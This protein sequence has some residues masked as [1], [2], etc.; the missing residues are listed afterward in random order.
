MSAGAGGR[1]KGRVMPPDGPTEQLRVAF[2]GMTGIFTRLVLQALLDAGTVVSGVFLA[3]PA[4][5]VLSPTVPAA[6]SERVPSTQHRANLATAPASRARRSLLPVADASPISL[7][8]DAGIPV[9]SVPRWD[10]LTLARLQSLV[11]DVIC[12]ACFPFR[13][14]PSVLT[15]PRHGCLNVHPSLLP[16]NRG[17]DPLFWTF[18]RGD[19]VTGVTIHQMD[20]GLDSGP[21]LL[22]ARITLADGSTEAALERQCAAVG[23]RLL[24]DALEALRTGK[25]APQR[26]D[27]ARA[28]RYGFPTEDDYWLA[29]D[30]DARTLFTFARGI[31]QRET[32]LRVQVD[33]HTYRVRA[34]LGYEQHSS[35]SEAAVLAGDELWLQCVNGGRLH[36]RVV[37]ER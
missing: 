5:L 21:I 27:Q 37:P 30:R 18:Q 24:V 29:P 23:G 34:A 33:G 2:L 19:T 13:L 8:R 9:Y 14:P 28:T 31:G 16:D 15:L 7:A 36:L 22:Q 35:S 26:Q 32:P 25:S 6:M 17:P 12:V 3:L 10:E 20:N 1:W 4:G 11:P